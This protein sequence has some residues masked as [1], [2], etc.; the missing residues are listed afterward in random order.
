MWKSFCLKLLWEPVLKFMVSTFIIVS[1][2]MKLGFRTA[3]VLFPA[4]ITSYK[5]YCVFR[6]T[7][8]WFVNVINFVRI[9][10]FKNLSFFHQLIQ[11]ARRPFPTV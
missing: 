6:I 1:P 11:L 9:L 4:L 10:L 3:S 8:K 2:I 7:I 5:I